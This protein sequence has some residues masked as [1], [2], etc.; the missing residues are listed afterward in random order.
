MADPKVLSVTEL[1]FLL[2]NVLEIEF[3]EVWVAGEISNLSRPQSGHCYFTLKDND[4]Q[5][6]GVLWRGTAERM[7]FDLKDGMQVICVGNIDLYPPRGTYQLVV[8]FAEPTG[9]GPLQVAFKQLHEKLK[10]EGLFDSV[11]KKT[12]PRIPERIGV[13]TSP[14]G[15]AVRD[16][17]QVLNRRWNFTDIT[18]IPTRVQGDEA[19]VEIANA[20]RV[21]NSVLPKFDV[22]VITRGGGSLE[23]LWCFNEE[24]VVR[25]IAASAIPTISA[26]GHEI[27]VTLS[28]LAADERALTP[29][30][31]AEKVVPSRDEIIRSVKRSKDY[32]NQL[33]FSKLESAVEKLKQIESR[34]IFRKPLESIRNFQRRLDELE[35]DAN[36][37]IRQMTLNQKNQVAALARQLE[38]V[39]PLAVLQRGYSVTQLTD[40]KSTLVNSVTSIEIGDL[41]RTQVADGSFIGRVETISKNEK[42]NP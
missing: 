41:V 26:I 33:L 37:S 28:D 42:K 18:I 10:A 3:P 36:R 8:R 11:R 4:A 6:R 22:I 21:A 29:S 25:A 15:A 40:D 2:K 1:S 19:T 7:K 20:I 31:A 13:I 24:E 9:I 5:I 23:D 39:S 12:I 17:L 16:F 38:S 32:L 30:E 34:P 14:T 27:D 35:T